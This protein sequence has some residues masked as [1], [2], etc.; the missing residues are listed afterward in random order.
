MRSAIGKLTMDTTFE[1]RDILNTQIVNIINEAAMPWGMQC[2]RYEI[3]DIK[4]PTNV[5]KS[6]EMQVAAERQKRA[7][8]LESE[9]KMQA[10][11]NSAEAKKQQVVLNSEAEMTEKVNRAKG[12]SEAIQMVAKATA[13]S[14]ENVAAAMQKTGGSDAVSFRVAEQYIEAF[15]ALAKTGNT[16]IVP[17]NTS[18]AG[19][20]IGQAFGIFNSLKQAKNNEEI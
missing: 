9:G 15:K 17:A 8:I 12:E 4:P 5:L 3:K 14:I 16:I 1:E 10:T 11:I 18:D 19:S 7:E 2:M 13:Q 20:M 6:M